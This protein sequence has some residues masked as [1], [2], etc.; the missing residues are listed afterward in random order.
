MLVNVLIGGLVSFFYWQQPIGIEWIY[1]LTIGI[2][3]FIGQFFM[4]QALQISE[5]NMIVPFK[6][7]EV[8]FSLILAL[9]IFGEQQTW[10]SLLGILLIMTGLIGNYLVKVK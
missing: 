2:V 9:L 6:Y 5:S 4:T 1:I 8:I 7:S 10:I 3:G